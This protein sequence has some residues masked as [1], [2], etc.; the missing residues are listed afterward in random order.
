MAAYVHCNYHSV[1]L[2]MQVDVSILL[3]EQHRMERIQQGTEGQNQTGLKYQTLYLLHG[4]TEDH[5]SYLR[6][7]KIERYAD[8][9]QIMVVMPS[10][11]NSAYTD[12]QYGLE[13]FTYLRRELVD[14]VESNFPAAR[15]RENRFVAGMS[16]GGYGA[17]KWG[18]TE[19]ERFAAIA[20]VAG[21]YHAEYRYQ[22]KVNTV[23]TLCEALYGD[24]PAMTPE[25]HD[26]FTMLTNLRKE[27]REIPRLYTCCGTEDRR[28][29]DSVDLKEHCDA[30]GIPLVFEEGPGR[31]DDLFF[32]EYIP[33]ILDWM[34]FRGGPV[35]E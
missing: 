11:Y 17:Y 29:Q 6:R 27:G 32:D 33:R 34:G 30:L 19:P 5:L 22:G 35:E 25:I 24:P 26:V 28:H 12:M 4:F 23:S 9:H 8:A 16:M 13:Y 18:L 3:P 20:G 10:V 14:F 21:S 1:I 15:T 2:R 31:H 7:T